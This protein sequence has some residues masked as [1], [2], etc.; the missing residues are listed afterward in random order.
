MTEENWH[1][2]RRRTYYKICKSCYNKEA[3]KTPEQQKVYRDKHPE[4]RQFWNRKQKLKN[5]IEVLSH[6]ANP[7]KCAMCGE[8]DII[9]LSID[10][11][12][13]GGRKHMAEVGSGD[14]F[15]YWLKRNNYPEGYQVLC[16]NCQLRKLNKH[17]Y[18][19]LP[20]VVDM[21]NY[22]QKGDENGI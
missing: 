5:K 17:L 20:E 8:T 4:K 12:N 16:M 3:T 10:H 7:L 2:S 21:N 15:R 1:P 22:N 11:I 6:Y 18:S 13:G 19:I 9:V 14:S